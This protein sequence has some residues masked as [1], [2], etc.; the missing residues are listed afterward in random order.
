MTRVG[1]KAL[2]EK[3]AHFNNF[4]LTHGHKDRLSGKKTGEFLRGLRLEIT[5]RQLCPGRV[6]YTLWYCRG[7]SFGLAVH[8]RKECVSHDYVL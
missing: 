6:G 5:L 4:V 1:R 7:L 3:T 8:H 2:I